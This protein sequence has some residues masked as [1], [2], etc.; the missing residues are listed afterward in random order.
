MMGRQSDSGQGD[1]DRQEVRESQST[2][3]VQEHTS[4]VQDHVIRA[5]TTQSEQ[6]MSNTIRSEIEFMPNEEMLDNQYA[7]D[8]AG[9]LGQDPQLLMTNQGYLTVDQ[10]QLTSSNDFQNSQYQTS[11][12]NQVLY[13]A[14]SSCDTIEA[15]DL[16]NLQ[17]LHL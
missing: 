7:I 8:F 3:V 9:T 14:N 11:P 6:V 12:T 16:K 4:F 5:D 17:L 13:T 15:G 2:M 1:Q 10:H